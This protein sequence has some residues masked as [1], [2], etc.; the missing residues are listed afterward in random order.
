MFKTFMGP[1]RIIARIHR[2]VGVRQI[3]ERLVGFLVPRLFCAPSASS[4][5]VPSCS[6]L[7]GLEQN[8]WDAVLSG[9]GSKARIFR[10][11][12]DLMFNWLLPRVASPADI[13]SVGQRGSLQTSAA[14]AGTAYRGLLERGLDFAIAGGSS[15]HGPFSSPGKNFKTVE[16]LRGTIACV[17]LT[18]ATVTALKRRC[19]QGLEYPR[20]YRFSLVAGGSASNL[21]AFTVRSLNI[22]VRRSPVSAHTRRRG[23]RFQYTRA[24]AS[25]PF[26]IFKRPPRHQTLVGRKNRS[27]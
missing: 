25:M 16:D 23:V 7:R 15:T 8:T 12:K 19:E 1:C 11:N 20:D 27:Q 9:L 17:F 21:Q 10:G 22:G 14:E 26:L 3:P 2:R 13:A 5:A 4:K 24:A 6:L 18:S